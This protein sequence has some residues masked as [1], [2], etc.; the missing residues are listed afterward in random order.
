MSKNDW[1]RVFDHLVLHQRNHS[2]DYYYEVRQKNCNS[3]FTR[4]AKLIYLN[5]T[6]WNGL[7]R[8]NLKGK[9]NVPIGTKTKVIHAEESFFEISKLLQNAEL[10]NDDF[11]N[12]IDRTVAGDF[13]F[14][15]PPHTVK[16]NYNGFVKYNE[17]LFAWDDQ[18]RLRDALIRAANRK[19]KILLTNA[20]HESVIQLY[21]D[22]F[23][24]SVV[25][26]ASVI[27]GSNIGRGNYEEII[28]QNLN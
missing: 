28:V 19:V 10:N 16:H 7:Y 26:R 20:C 17:N 4:A 13:L 24:I 6:C 3:E 1:Q 14:I 5:R 9:F 21:E 18:I 11:E 2:K 8:I 15:D 12:T 27:A 25:K 22:I 23:R